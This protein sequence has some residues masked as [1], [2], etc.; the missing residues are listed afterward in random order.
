[1]VFEQRIRDG[2]ETLVYDIARP[3]DLDEA[4]VL[5]VD[6]YNKSSPFTEIDSISNPSDPVGLFEGRKSLIKK[7]FARPTSII[8]REKITNEVIAF[9]CMT[10]S[11]RRDHSAS[12]NPNI[13][14]DRSQPGWL[15]EAME[16]ELEKGIDLFEHY[17]TNRILYIYVHRCRQERLPTGKNFLI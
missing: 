17:G 11:E 10:I 4:A 15:I 6:S 16:K 5:A 3:E 2:K 14:I 8:I 1:M 7:C 12:C 13:D 9:S